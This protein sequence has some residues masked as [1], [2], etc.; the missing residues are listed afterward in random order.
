MCTVFRPL[1]GAGQKRRRELQL[2]C[3][4]T[5]DDARLRGND[6]A[7]CT[8]HLL[9]H[10]LGACRRCRSP[11]LYQDE[12]GR[13]RR[14]QVH[15]LTYRSVPLHHRGLYRVPRLFRLPHIGSRQNCKTI[16]NKSIT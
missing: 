3:G 11:D 10:C 4:R 13:G 5:G 6:D 12:Y 8:L 15:R 7:V 2:G 16:Q 9:C 14:G 1:R